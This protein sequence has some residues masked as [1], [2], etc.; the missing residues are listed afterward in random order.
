M[1][2][3]TVSFGYFSF[4]VTGAE[5]GCELGSGAMPA[6]TSVDR[7]LCCMGRVDMLLPR[8]ADGFWSTA[9][10]IEDDLE[11]CISVLTHYLAW[12]L[13]TDQLTCERV[14][15]RKAGSMTISRLVC[16]VPP[17]STFSMGRMW[18]A[19]K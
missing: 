9:V 10:S 13:D 16:L 19:S 18:I 17:P 12:L 11:G 5:S 4:S 3:L 15:I 6:S 8:A 14:S 1:T 7:C 2:T